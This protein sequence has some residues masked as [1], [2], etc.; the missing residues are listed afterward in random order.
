MMLPIGRTTQILTIVQH[1]KKHRE[2][3]SIPISD[4]LNCL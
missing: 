3:I 4:I 2:T 1:L